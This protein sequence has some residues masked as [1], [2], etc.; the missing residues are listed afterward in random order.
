[1]F[2]FRLLTEDELPAYLEYFIPDYAAEI[3][4]NYGLS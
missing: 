3:V 2:T 1:M 4:K